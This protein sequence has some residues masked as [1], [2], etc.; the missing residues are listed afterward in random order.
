MSIALPPAPTELPPL[1]WGTNRK[2]G[3]YYAG[4]VHVASN[5]SGLAICGLPIEDIWPQRPANPMLCPDCALA[6][7]QWVY[8]AASIS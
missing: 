6:V 3:L 8:P 5:M 4:R 2:G 7:M 1:L